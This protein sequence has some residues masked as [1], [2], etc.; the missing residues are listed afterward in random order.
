M[1][2]KTKGSFDRCPFSFFISVRHNPVG[3][4]ALVADVVCNN[5]LCVCVVVCNVRV[6]IDRFD[7]GLLSHFL[8]LF[9]LSAS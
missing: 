9:F 1:N 6:L 7:G 3:N 5:L 4:R 2:E 8:S